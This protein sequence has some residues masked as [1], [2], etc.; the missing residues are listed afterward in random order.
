MKIK[1]GK[2]TQIPNAFL[3][4]PHISS[5]TKLVFIL[6]DSFYANYIS[7]SQLKRFGA[8]VNDMSIRRSI[9][10]LIER[11]ILDYKKGNSNKKANEYMIFEETKNWDLTTTKKEMKTRL[12]KRQERE[13]SNNVIPMGLENHTYRS[14]KPHFKSNHKQ[15]TERYK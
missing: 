3:Q 2:F 13:L 10:E 11:G 1:N 12:S 6:I 14:P 15:F 9:L 8:P 4:C 7:Y 5:S